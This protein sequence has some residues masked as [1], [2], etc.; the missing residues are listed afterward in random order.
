MDQ[1]PL[2]TLYKSLSARRRPEDVAETIGEVLGGVLS[3]SESRIL[4]R[5]A[6]GSLKRRLFGVTSMLEEFARP[7]GMDRQ[8]ARARELFQS[9]Y[10][11]NEDLCS[12]PEAVEQF[13]RTISKE[14][15]KS[16]GASDFRHDRLSKSQRDGL[17]LEFS[18]RGY[19]KRFR[20]LARMEAKLQRLVREIR[21]REFRMIGKSGLAS[22][23]TWAEFAADADSA[24][25]GPTTR[26]GGT[27]ARS[28]PSPA[29]RRRTTR[30]PR[31]CC[32]AASV[33]RPRAGGRSRTSTRASRSSGT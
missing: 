31:C 8:V 27:C 14:I 23:L 10:P 11:L 6:A 29:S 21:K 28:S 17:G 4:E 22:R 12:N 7:V 1:T 2:R 33:A 15:G 26:P 30:W 25:F 19:N 18:R 32:P 20:L 13:I 24:C 16:V 5:A 9:A 3:L